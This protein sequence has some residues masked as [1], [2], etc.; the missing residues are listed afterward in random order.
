MQYVPD[1]HNWVFEDHAG[2]T[3]RHDFF[4]LFLH[5]LFVAVNRTN[6]AGRFVL[7][8]R[9]FGQAEFCEINKFKA[10]ITQVV[11]FAVWVV[12]FAKHLDHSRRRFM[13]T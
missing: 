3:V 4:G 9:A 11:S 12:F 5:V 8:V 1:G 7:P 10:V 2:A 6:P 13:F